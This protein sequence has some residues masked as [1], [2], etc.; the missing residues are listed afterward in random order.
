V[1]FFHA[2]K[3]SN[4]EFGGGRKASQ[5]CLNEHAKIKYTKRI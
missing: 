1:V 3:D 4:L 5:A 2:A